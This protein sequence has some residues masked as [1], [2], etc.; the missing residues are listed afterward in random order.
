MTMTPLDSLLRIAVCGSA[1]TSISL[2]QLI[3]RYRQTHSG[4]NRASSPRI[5]A[6]VPPSEL[7]T[8]PTSAYDRA[9]SAVRV[10][11]LTFATACSQ[12]GMLATGTKTELANTRGKMTTKPADCAASAPP[13][14]SATKAKI[15][16]RPNPK[17]LT[18][19]T[20]RTPPTSPA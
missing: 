19:A 1:T 7:G 16:L 9:V 13:T 18:T 14:V 6:A 4:M 5:Q 3:R 12:P 10:T 20:D 11:G 8:P 15:Q 17:P 2:A